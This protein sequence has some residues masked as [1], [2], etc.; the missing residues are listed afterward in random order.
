MA[1]VLIV[2]DEPNV[3][4]SFEKGLRRAIDPLEVI[5]AETGREALRSIDEFQPDAVILD[6]RLPDLSG[7]DVCQR[8]CENHSQIPVIIVTAHATMDTAISAMKRGA[9]D[10]LLKPVDIHQLTALVQKTLDVSRMQPLAALPEQRSA[11]ATSERIIGGSPAMQEVYKSIG[12]VAREHLP[13]LVVGE[14]GTGKELVAR[15]L[16]QYSSRSKKAFV[17]INCAALPETLLESELFGHERG[18]FTGADQQRIGKF[19]QAHRGTLFLDEL[20][21][22][23][24]ATQA[25]LLRVLQDGCVQRVGGNKLIDTDVRIIAATNQD[26]DEKM[27]QGD[28]REDLYYR[29]NGLTIRLPPLRDRTEDVP[30]LTQ[31]ILRDLNI[32]LRRKVTKLAPEALSLLERYHWPGNIRELQAVI[33]YA[34]LHSVGEVITPECLPETCLSTGG[35]A[36]NR[37]PDHFGDFK[38]INRELQ[39]KGFQW[40]SQHI[41]ELLHSGKSEL[42]RELIS[43]VE[44]ILLR[45]VLEHVDGNQV[46]ASQRLGISRTTLRSKLS[47][48]PPDQPPLGH[49]DG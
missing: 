7:L 42:Y 43:E 36:A 15:T 27:Q 24:L 16:H 40:L 46:R 5:T 6:V 8:I 41:R 39:A 10:Y 33:R 38:I 17:P 3:L 20:G 19:E 4:Y 12:R 34:V 29:L 49:S 32:E 31:H 47:N 13:V 14:S 9:F 28:F 48:L 1:R 35:D 18:A 45:E 44:Q 21:D 2:D 25:K 11:S 26:L 22:M 23:S 37:G 30:I